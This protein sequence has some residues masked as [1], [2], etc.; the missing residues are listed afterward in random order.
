MLRLH[1][2]VRSLDAR[3]V[4]LSA[5]RASRVLRHLWRLEVLSLGQHQYCEALLPALASL[6]MLRT[7]HLS[8]L[9]TV[10]VPGAPAPPGEPGPLL[11]SA[12]LRELTL[13]NGR[14]TRLTVCAPALELLRL[15]GFLVVAPVLSGA[16][17]LRCMEIEGALRGKAGALDAP[18]PAAPSANGVHVLRSRTPHVVG[19]RVPACLPAPCRL[20]QA[21]RARAVVAAAR[22]R[23]AGAPGHARAP[24]GGRC[25]APARAAPPGA[26]P[27]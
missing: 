26:A 20:H 25:A 15:R 24:G 14:A 27:S 21:H 23:A 10:P 9:D 1:T 13:E 8:G 16:T 6:P 5:E 17:A 4:A 22:G 18:S 7:L 2:G 19:P 3:G 12:T 11:A